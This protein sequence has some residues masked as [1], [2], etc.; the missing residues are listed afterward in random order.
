MDYSTAKEYADKISSIIN[1]L[2]EFESN[3]F[4]HLNKII[5]EETKSE[6]LK[7]FNDWYQSVP[8]DLLIRLY[9]SDEIKDIK[10]DLKEE[11][12]AVTLRL[13][14]PID[15]PFEGVCDKQKLERKGNISEEKYANIQK[16]Y[17]REVKQYYRLI[18]S[19]I[20]YP[21]R[22]GYM[23]DDNIFDSNIYI[24]NNT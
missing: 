18:R 13:L 22:M 6:E 2:N 7:S 1:R 21:K 4:V 15:F 20:R 9:G 11:Y 16:K 23:L 14:K 19:T 10:E 17:K 8:T 5:E 12:E 24:L 3:D